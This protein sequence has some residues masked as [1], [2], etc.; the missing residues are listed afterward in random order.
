MNVKL[1]QMKRITL[2][3]LALLILS[4]NELFAELQSE[5]ERIEKV[6]KPTTDFS[7]PELFELFSAG[8]ATVF[9]NIDRHSFS[10]S[11]ANM[12]FE[13]QLDFKVG[14]AIFEKLWVSAPAST[15]SSDGLGP[16]F[17]ARSC[18]SC[19]LKNGRGHTP[20]V[21][22]PAAGSDSIFLRLSIPPQNAD[23]RRLLA[24]HH[25]NV[26]P[27]P[28]YG[29]QLQERSIQGHLAEAKM[30]IKY[31]DIL[32][33]FSD[34]K[35]IFLRKPTYSITDWQYGE[36]HSEL[37]ISPR[38]ASPMIGLGLL[39]AISKKDIL[40][41]ADPDDNNYDGISGKANQVWDI[42]T[43]SVKLGRFGWKA[44]Q[45]DI[46]QQSSAAA[47]GDIGLSV[48]F[49]SNAWGDCTAAQKKCRNAPNGNTP[50]QNNLE[51]SV[52]A[53]N[54][55]V[56]FAKNVGVPA[57]RNIDDRQ[58]LAG[59]KLFFE[60]GC[61]SCH[62]P[63]FVTQR[64]PQQPEQSFQ[65]IW[66]YTDLLL[67]D[68][69]EGLADHR[70]EGKASGFEWRTAP[71]WGIGLTKTVNGHTEFLHDGRARNLLEAILW[72]GGEAETA[73]QKTLQFNQ[74]QRSALLA[75]LNSL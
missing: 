4:D 16:I 27:A 8:G 42:R 40:D 74:N 21:S 34:G 22:N 70:P 39:E 63:K 45:P 47:N 23:Q 60:S 73:K 50:T 36:P 5:I 29:T 56:F 75:F 59:K 25:S 54:K 2:F 30:Q 38:V 43:Q 7:K 17:N 44:G 69:G 9:Q 33:K 58:V 10:H 49:N 64:L 72:H 67:H 12:S 66:P 71:L 32:L 24:E 6:V 1:F 14:S 61:A 28:I 3:L 48:P 26:I 55:M 11:S 31:Q 19:H 15:I 65:L 51:I 37:M 46:Y 68:M 35:E 13:R 20:S 57:R 52:Q 18:H 41:N 62:R 53:I